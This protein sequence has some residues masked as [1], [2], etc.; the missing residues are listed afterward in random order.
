MIFFHCLYPDQKLGNTRRCNPKWFLKAIWKGWDSEAA[1]LRRH[2]AEE[3]SFFRPTRRPVEAM[4]STSIVSQRLVSGAQMNLNSF[5]KTLF[6]RGTL[7]SAQG[8]IP[9]RS[10]G[11]F[12]PPM[13][14]LKCKLPCITLSLP[15]NSSQCYDW[16]R[17]IQP[18]N[19]LV[20]LFCYL[21]CS[22]CLCFLIFS[23]ILD[24]QYV[25]HRQHMG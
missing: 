11:N 2:V 22:I 5:K 1:K 16:L 14:Q 3:F 21:F 19:A 24:V 15:E 23:F 20:C 7:H 17:V 18:F 8:H 10:L 12:T 9:A 25:G 4:Y 6:Q 13:I